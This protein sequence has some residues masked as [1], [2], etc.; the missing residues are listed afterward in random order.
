M[1]KWT[2][3]CFNPL[4]T[5]F[6]RD[7]KPFG[8]ADKAQTRNLPM[9]QTTAGAVRT[10]LMESLGCDFEGLADS[11]EFTRVMQDVSFRGPWFMLEDELLFPVPATLVETEDCEIQALKPLDTSKTPLPGWEPADGMKPL[12]RKDSKP[13]KRLSKPF[14]KLSGMKTFLGGGVPG[15]EDFVSADE[16]YGHDRRTGIGVDKNT[17]TAEDGQIYAVNLLALKDK[18]SLYMEVTAPKDI[19]EILPTKENPSV[20]KL[21]GEGR[22]AQFHRVNDPALNFGDVER[23]RENGA[24]LVLLTPG[25][26]NGWKPAML[27]G[28]LISAAVPGYEAVSGWDLKKGGPK[29]NRFAV[30]AGS[31]YFVD[32]QLGQNIGSLCDGEDAR[33][34]YGIYAEG[35]FDYA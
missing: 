19:S 1:D 2:G 29:P 15:K 7:G 9:P 3:L 22:Y 33:L 12:W 23:N 28:N 6:F 14:I 17:L 10:W 35:R 5:L 31:V 11:A 25:L 24:M 18:V 26:F 8:T 13:A 21:G 30:S 27:N 16:V 32:K 4:D 34:G 20:I